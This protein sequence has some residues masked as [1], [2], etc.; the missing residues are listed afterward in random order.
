[1]TDLAQEQD[2][3]KRQKSSLRSVSASSALCKQPTW[4]DCPEEDLSIQ[5]VHQRPSQ[6]VLPSVSKVSAELQPECLP[7]VKRRLE[8]D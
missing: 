3:K 6:E 2:G 5:R 1:M 8:R 7:R 4:P